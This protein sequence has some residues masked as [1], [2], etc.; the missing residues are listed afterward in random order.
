MIKD[1]IKYIVLSG[2][3]FGGHYFLSEML[4]GKGFSNYRE[5]AHLMLFTLFIASHILS[6][7]IS[8]KSSVLPG[9]IFLGF[10]V[11]KLISA[12]L[13]IFI[14]KQLSEVDISKAY[15]L[16]F[17]ASYFTFLGLDVLLMLKALNKP[18]ND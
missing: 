18:N 15:I 6:K 2:L 1:L 5:E 17:M 14:I 7:I 13:F 12:G 11:V 8:K 4:P 3:L 9:Q 16:V 10:S